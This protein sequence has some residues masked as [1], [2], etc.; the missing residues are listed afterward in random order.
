MYSNVI[1]KHELCVAEQFNTSFLAGIRGTT[2]AYSYFN[3]Y[4]ALN[5]DA[6]SPN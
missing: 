2:A 1:M 4:Y 5:T 3:W 6:G